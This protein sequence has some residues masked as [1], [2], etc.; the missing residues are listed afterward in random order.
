[1]GFGCQ[2]PRRSL[3]SSSSMRRMNSAGGR[4]SPP[5]LAELIEYAERFELYEL[6][7]TLEGRAREDELREERREESGPR[8]QTQTGHSSSPRMSDD[9]LRQM[10]ARLA[11]TDTDFD[12]RAALHSRSSP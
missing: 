11:P 1:M 8:R 5:N 10:F 12:C 4:P 9:A 6:K 3:P 7:E 2:V